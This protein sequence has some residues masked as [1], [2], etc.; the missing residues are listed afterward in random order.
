M[1]LLLL[2]LL[3]ILALRVEMRVDANI[4]RETLRKCPEPVEGPPVSP[5]GGL[6]Y[7]QGPHVDD[8]DE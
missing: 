5:G 4:R 7:A 6:T 1:L 3:V 8:D 2:L